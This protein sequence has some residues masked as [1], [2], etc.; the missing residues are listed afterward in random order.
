M[1]R[2]I[3]DYRIVNDISSEN[4]HQKSNIKIR[5]RNYDG[6]MNK[7]K[8]NS[9]VNKDYVCESNDNNTQTMATGAI[10]L[11]VITTMIVEKINK[12]HMWYKYQMYT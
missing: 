6:N 11:I 7:F 2:S 12:M 5:L 10:P 4:K 8:G 1:E 3:I 9:N